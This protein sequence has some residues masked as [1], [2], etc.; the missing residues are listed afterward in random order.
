[1]IAPKAVISNWRL[2]FKKWIPEV[3]VCNLIATKDQREG[4]IKDVILP[5]NFD[6]AL[7]TY[8]GV[9]LCMHALKK[10]KW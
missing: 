1:V 10:F 7:T 3:K 8:E 5:G 6:V 9:R 4:I 2:E